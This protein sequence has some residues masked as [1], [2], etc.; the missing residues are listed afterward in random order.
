MTKDKD[1]TLDYTKFYFTFGSGQLYDNCY[2]VIQAATKQ[3]ARDMML[4]RYGIKWSMMYNSA[5]EAG[6]EEFGLREIK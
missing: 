4:E 2:H 1:A 6:V 5:E 3:D